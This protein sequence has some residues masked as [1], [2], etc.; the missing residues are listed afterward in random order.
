LTNTASRKGGAT[1]T[2]N[3]RS[4]LGSGEFSV[5]TTCHGQLGPKRTCSVTVA[6]APCSAGAT[7]ATVT[8]KGNATNSPQVIGVIGA[9][10]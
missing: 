6:F 3:G 9:G 5:S 8:I 4:V 7:S 10:K 1:V 2:F